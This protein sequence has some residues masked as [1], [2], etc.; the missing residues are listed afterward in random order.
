LP[1]LRAQRWDPA[2]S[3]ASSTVRRHERL[4]RSPGYEHDVV[5]RDDVAMFLAKCAVVR[6]HI[7]VAPIEHREYAVG[8]FPIDG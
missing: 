6:G 3:G 7:L 1:R 4:T 8:D 5:H 2:Y